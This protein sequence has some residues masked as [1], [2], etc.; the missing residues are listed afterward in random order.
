MHTDWMDF[1]KHTTDLNAHERDRIRRLLRAL[2][3]QFDGVFVLNTDHRD[4]LTSHAMGLPEDKVHL[5]AHHSE[6]VRGTVA[7]LRKSEL[8]PGATA[9]TPVMFYAGRI[10]KEKGVLELAQIYRQARQSIPDLHL[11]IAGSGPAEAELR[12][13]VPEAHF[14]GWISRERMAQLY[15]GLDLFVFPSKFDTFGNV[16]LEAFSH[17]MPAV[18]YGC[19]GPKGIVQHGRN[20]YLVDSQEQM[21][22]QVVRYFQEPER[23]AA[24]RR[25]AVKRAADYEAEP[26]MRQ[27]LSD[28]G[29]E[30]AA[31]ELERSVA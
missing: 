7:P 13:A 22:E 31:A 21:A 16:L 27:F 2:Y 15:A 9:A 4:W 1:V 18:A 19:K 3:H 20:G 8:I 14:T 28:M 17:G 26:I 30:P 12:Q 29:L 23:H 6:P 5:T 25:E 11:V 24:M 10:S